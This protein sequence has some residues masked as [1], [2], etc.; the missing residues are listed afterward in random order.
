MITLYRFA[1]EKYKDDLSGEG[2]RLFG[3]RWN[4]RGFSVVYTSATISLALL[5]LL[6]HSAAYEEIMTKYLMVL[7][8]SISD[9]IPE[10]KSNKL[11]EDW[12]EDIN[13]TKWMGEEFLKSNSSLLLQVPSAIIPEEKNVLIN[14][15]HKD[16]NKVKVK[17]A[18]QFHFDSRLF[19]Y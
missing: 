18:T 1:G 7:E 11:K 10:I 17:R 3:G 12:I 8:I 14:P 2:S 15:K 5:E 13:S 19:K 16:I 9:S 4:N 6:I